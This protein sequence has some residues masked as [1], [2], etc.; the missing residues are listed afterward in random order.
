MIATTEELDELD[1]RLLDALQSNARSTFA[2]LGSI[3]GLKAPAVHDRVK[4]LEQR[5]YI[6]RYSAQLDAK[7]L[8]LL[9]TAFVSLYTAP[10]CNYDDFTRALGDMPEVCEVHSVA[11]EE[12]FVCKVVTGSTKHLDDLLARLKAMPGMARTRTT[13]VLTTPYDRGGVTVQS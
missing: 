8:G 4:R 3:V 2:E 1:L 5:G 7:R 13:I 11:G 9:L 10:D 12:T 6:Q